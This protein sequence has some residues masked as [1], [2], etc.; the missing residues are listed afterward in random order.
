MIDSGGGGGGGGGGGSGAVAGKRACGARSGAG[1]ARGGGG[2]GGAVAFKP[3]LRT[4]GD[5]AVARALAASYEDEARAERASAGCGGG[6]GGGHAAGCSLLPSSCRCARV[7]WLFAHAPAAPGGAA[8]AGLGGKFLFFPPPARVDDDWAK[9]ARLVRAGELGP[10]AKVNPAPPPDPRTHVI[11]VYVSD[12][13]NIADVAR[14]LQRARAAGFSGA[15]SFKTDFATRS[16]VYADERGDA[17][18]AAVAAQPK[19]VTISRYIAPAADEDGAWR[20]D[21]CHVRRGGGGGGGGGDDPSAPDARAL[22]VEAAN[23]D[24]ALSC[25]VP[26]VRARVAEWRPGDAAPRLGFSAFVPP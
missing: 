22:D 12:A 26:H 11:C 19:G 5:E 17:A 10:Q 15:L 16:G 1:G 8:R 14:V 4:D 18:R 21:L 9:L 7:E 23:V 6:G 20:L 3:S 2:G 24:E 13:G 25:L